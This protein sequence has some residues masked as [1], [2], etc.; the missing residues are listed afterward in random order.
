M[1]KS[2]IVLS[3]SNNALVQFSNTSYCS[4][5][6]AV[7]CNISSFSY[8]II[9]IWNHLNL[10]HHRIRESIVQWN[11]A[12][13]EFQWKILSNNSTYKMNKIEEFS[14]NRCQ[15]RKI[16]KN[17][18]ISINRCQIRKRAHLAEM[19]KQYGPLICYTTGCDNWISK[20][21]KSY[22]TA[23]VVGHLGI[24]SGNNLRTQRKQKKFVY[25]TRYHKK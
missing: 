6:C 8:A 13:K 20:N 2:Q 19:L 22:L 25:N 9:I 15:I 10:L 16:N 18:G 5:S 1:F 24:Q 21:L 11:I 7:S 17:Q 4:S 12:Y 14:I 3:Q 23:K